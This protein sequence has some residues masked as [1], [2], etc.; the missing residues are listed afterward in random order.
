MK[1]F[2]HIPAF[3]RNKFFIAAICFATWLLFFDRND[4]FIQR[5]RQKELKELRQ[6]KSYYQ[7]EIAEEGKFAQDL[8]HNPATIEKFARE[9]YGMKRDNEDLF[10]VQPVH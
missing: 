8:K 1:L 3:M 9:K 5:E 7:K 2:S 4:F 6:S 10:L